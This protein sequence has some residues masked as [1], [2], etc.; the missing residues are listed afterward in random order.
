MQLAMLQQAVW[1][2]CSGLCHLVDYGVVSSANYSML[3]FCPIHSCT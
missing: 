1:F 3:C 2:S